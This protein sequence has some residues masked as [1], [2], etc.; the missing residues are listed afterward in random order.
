MAGHQWSK[1]VRQ[2][3]A[4]NAKCGKL[5]PKLASLSTLALATGGS[6]APADS[7]SRSVSP[8]SRGSV[9]HTGEIERSS[10][11]SVPTNAAFRDHL[12]E[13]PFEASPADLSS[14]E[15]FHFNI[16]PRD[17]LSSVG[18][19]LFEA[20]REPDSTTLICLRPTATPLGNVT[21]A[22]HSL[23]ISG[24]PGK[25]MTSTTSTR[26]LTLQKNRW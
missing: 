7:A 14:G 19:S 25:M 1:A 4:L 2:H 9:A 17:H 10:H 5:I 26:T 22:A 6:T 18:D 16:T 11:G 13:C 8:V 15:E 3:S 24:A 12:L 23:R 20:D 21:V